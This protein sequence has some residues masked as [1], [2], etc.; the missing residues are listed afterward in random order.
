MRFS[1]DG[2]AYDRDDLK[3]QYDPMRKWRKNGVKSKSQI[4]KTQ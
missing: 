1:Q 4:A 2:K 3:I